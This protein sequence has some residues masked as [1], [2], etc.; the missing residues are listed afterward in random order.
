MLQ[1]VKKLPVN[2]Y[3]KP[4]QL[5]HLRIFKSQHVCKIPTIIKGIMQWYNLSILI[6]P[7]ATERY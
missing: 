1:L 5:K 3:I 2:G 6:N 7:S 4:H